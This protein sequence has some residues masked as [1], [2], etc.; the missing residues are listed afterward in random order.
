MND[1]AIRIA[2]LSDTHLG[3]EA[4]PARAASGNNQRGEDFVRAFR[5][6]VE[7]ILAWDPDVVIHSGDVADRPKVDIRYMLVAQQYFRRLGS[8]RPDGTRRQ[9]VVI[10][11]NHDL[12][13]SRKEACWLDLLIGAPGLHIATHRYERFMFDPKRD[14]VRPELGNLVVHAIPHDTLKDV[15]QDRIVPT[16]GKINVLTTH[17]VASGSELFLRA[18]GRE[19]PVDEDVLLR[20]WDYVA[21][22]HWH[23][24]GPVALGPLGPRQNIWYAGS[25]ENSG[26][27]D[28]RDNSTT[29]GY[30]RVTLDGD[31]ADVEPVDLPIR[32]MLRLPVLDG[33]GLTTDQVTERLIE[34]L[35]AAE[36]I[37]GAIVGQVVTGVSRDRWSLVDVGQVRRHAKRALHYEITVRYTG[38]VE[39]LTIDAPERGYAHLLETV[40]EDLLEHVPEER[41]DAVEAYIRKLLGDVDTVEMTPNDGDETT[42]D[43]DETEVMAT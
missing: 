15:D 11:G 10:A 31:G 19:Y 36:E 7:D 34:H 41:R 20:D 12:S 40:G 24:R 21:L 5:N 16:G 2:H 35:D 26:F 4:Y 32:T 43:A 13:R 42:S 3:Y 6:A 29:R 8:I 33:D 30:L 18:Q 37:D 28:L 1:M 22:G 25:L 23:R 27:R 9:V 38:S 39:D 17:G 14:N